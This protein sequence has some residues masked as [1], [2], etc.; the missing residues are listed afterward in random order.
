MRRT[1]RLSQEAI[2]TARIART[3][4]ETLREAGLWGNGRVALKL[5]PETLVFFKVHD[6]IAV[7]NVAARNRSVT[8]VPLRCH[9][10]R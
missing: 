10:E 4:R 9:R 3:F 1:Q 2:G 6:E 5:T 8:G 7:W